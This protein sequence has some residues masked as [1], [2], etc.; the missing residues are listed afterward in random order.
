MHL[1][2]GFSTEK[3]KFCQQ[4][5]TISGDKLTVILNQENFL[6][7][8]NSYKVNQCLPNSHI[9]FK[10]AVKDGFNGRPMNGMLIAVPNVIKENIND[11]SPNH[12][13]VQAAIVKTNEEKVLILD[14]Y[15]PVDPR[16]LRFDDNE[17][18]E[19]FNAIDNVLESNE[20]SQI[21]WGGD[22]NCDFVRNTGFVQS[23]DRFIG[24]LN[25]VKAWERFPIDYTHV[26]EVGGVTFAS[27]IDHFFWN[28][29]LIVS[30]AGVLHIVDNMSDHEAIYCVLET[31]GFDKV[32][33][34]EEVTARPSNKPSWKKATPEQRVYFSEDL[35]QKLENINIPDC[36]LNCR[37]IHCDM[38]E[39]KNACDD[40]MASI[41]NSIEVSAK[42]TLYCEEVNKNF[43]RKKK[44]QPVPD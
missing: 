30:D 14:T 41:V 12:W 7:K 6:L 37:D 23:V 34:E 1:S 31:S 33:T 26:H 17:V 11:V 16:T 38:E 21:C 29:S 32:S 4:L 40:Y 39:H 20:F 35:H 25:L 9:I 43:G 19:V 22:I 42:E 18:L 5:E 15:F 2:R 3:Q 44:K 36:V 28:D 10:P 8:A 24:E 27:K 13:R